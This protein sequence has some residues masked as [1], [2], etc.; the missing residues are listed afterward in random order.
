MN[1]E[2]RSPATVERE[3]AVAYARQVLR[4]H[5]DEAS[6]GVVAMA[7]QLLRALGLSP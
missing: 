3:M 7:R 1:M 4:G 6:A 5:Q 2:Q